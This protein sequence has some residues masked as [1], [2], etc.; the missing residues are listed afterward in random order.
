MATMRDYMANKNAPT[1]FDLAEWYVNNCLRTLQQVD[2]CVGTIR[3][4]TTLSTNA[5]NFIE[6]HTGYLK[7]AT[8]QMVKNDERLVTSYDYFMEHDERIEDIET[9]A[10]II[11]KECMRSPYMK[12]YRQELEGKYELCTMYC[13]LYGMQLLSVL[14][15]GKLNHD[16]DGDI[17]FQLDMTKLVEKF[18]IQN[19]LR[20]S[21]YN[22][23][24]SIE[25]K[26]VLQ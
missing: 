25:H 26:S 10:V 6:T 17:S 13:F 5:N 22:W 23:L 20:S 11:I 2:K 7:I 21:R 3:K 15:I 9:A 8:D 1:D 4:N 16:D 14:K 19:V 24:K 12:V 18:V